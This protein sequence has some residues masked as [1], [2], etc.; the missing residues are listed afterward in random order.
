MHAVVEATRGQ[1]RLLQ[2]E[3]VATAGMPRDIPDE[4]KSRH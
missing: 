4:G 3:R 2:I 1:Y